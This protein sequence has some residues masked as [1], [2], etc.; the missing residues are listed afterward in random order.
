MAYGVDVDIA[1]LF[2]LTGV[3]GTD[4]EKLL[5]L[6]LTASCGKDGL[7]IKSDSAKLVA[8]VPGKASVILTLLAEYE[9]PASLSIAVDCQTLKAKV[10]AAFQE[11]LKNGLQPAQ[12]TVAGQLKSAAQTQPKDHVL[13]PPAKGTDLIFPLSEITTAPV[14]KLFEATRL[15][16]PVKGSGAQ[17]RYFAIA[18]SPGIKMA[19]RILPSRVS[20]RLEGPDLVKLSPALK[21]LGFTLSGG[22][23]SM[24][25]EI[26][27]VTEAG[28][29]VGAVI[30][31]LTDH[32]Q[33]STP[34]PQFQPLLNKGS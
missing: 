25:I 14:V 33:W 24:H 8:T 18:I 4:S 29:A 19:A 26:S 21:E 31:R 27:S 9:K 12:T 6:K 2:H 34:I 13:A 23:C 16:Q 3:Q 17:S 11:I 5:N 1:T 20:L 28:S 15:Y 30:G 10:W 32:V 7:V 22:Y